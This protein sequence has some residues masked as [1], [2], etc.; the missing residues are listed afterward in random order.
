MQPGATPSRVGISRNY[1][2]HLQIQVLK[3]I[4]GATTEGHAGISIYGLLKRS[5]RWEF[6]TYSGKKSHRVTDGEVA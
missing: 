6:E 5:T 2:V 3:Q 4:R 1:T